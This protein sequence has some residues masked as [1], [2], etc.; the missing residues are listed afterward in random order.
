[1]PIDG[2]FRDKLEPGTILVARYKGE[3]HAA[4][5]TA[6]DGKT[7]FRLADG[8]V[9]KSPSAAASAVMSGQAANGWR[10]WSLKADAPVAP[11]KPA[12][13]RKPKAETDAS[14]STET[15]ASSE[16]TAVG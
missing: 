14:E 13:T 1:M 8:R 11:V 3:E 10:F 6:E 7:R 5:V 2:G 15:E 9:F 4:E 12:K 16:E